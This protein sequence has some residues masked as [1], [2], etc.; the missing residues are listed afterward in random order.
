MI[1][2][3]FEGDTDLAKNSALFERVINF[4]NFLSRQNCITIDTIL[5]EKVLRCSD[6]GTVSILPSFPNGYCAE[7]LPEMKSGENEIT[8]VVWRKDSENNIK[9]VCRSKNYEHA[10]IQ[11]DVCKRC[12]TP[13]G[14]NFFQSKIRL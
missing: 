7:L 8:W 13:Q 5:K 14:W 11:F 9:T 4:L 10:K 2:M 3:T 12:L 6:E 1:V